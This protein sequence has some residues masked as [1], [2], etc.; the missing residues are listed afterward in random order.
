VVSEKR[1]KTESIGGVFRVKP[2][3]KDYTVQLNLDFLERFS[4]KYRKS[5]CTEICAVGSSRIHAGS[6]ADEQRDRQADTRQP[7]G[8]FSGYAKAPNDLLIFSRTLRMR[9]CCQR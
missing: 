7:I 5:N 4:S 6:R 9:N 1:K 8:A 2:L 3:S